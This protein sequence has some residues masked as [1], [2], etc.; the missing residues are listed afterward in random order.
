MST[1]ATMLEKHISDTFGQSLEMQKNSHLQYV[2]DVNTSMTCFYTTLMTL[3]NGVFSKATSLMTFSNGASSKDASLMTF[4]N[5][6]F[7]KYV[8]LMTLQQCAR[9]RRGL[10][11]HRRLL[12]EVVAG[13]HFVNHQR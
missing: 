8:S 7:T 4:S 12:H 6:M 5:D 13:D 1:A 11:C 2:Y 3:S 10:R 9:H